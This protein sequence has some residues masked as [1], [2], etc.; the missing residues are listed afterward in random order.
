MR[1]RV[2][3]VDDEPGMLE[4]AK[5]FLESGSGY[6]V[7]TVSSSHEALERFA[8]D[9]HDAIVS[10]Y[11][12]AGMDG[13][14]L[15]KEV[16]AMHN[17]VPFI[18]LTGKGREDVAIEAL[19][20]GADFYLQKGADLK[21]QF[22]ELANMIRA[23]VEQRRAELKAHKTSEMLGAVVR[24]SPTPLVTVDTQGKV[25]M[26]NLAAQ[27][28]FGWTE[29]EAIGRIPPLV[30]P[31]L[32]GQF[33]GL[34]ARILSGERLDGVELKRIRKD[35]TMRDVLAYY[36][37]ILDRDGKPA[38][39]MA[40]LVDVTDH[41]RMEEELR[42][43]N[44][45][46][47]L[48]SKTNATIVMAKDRNNLL[49]QVCKVAVEHG[50]FSSAW[51]CLFGT[52]GELIPIASEGADLDKLQDI[53]RRMVKA[54]ALEAPT[55]KAAKEG[56]T[57]ISTDIYSDHSA[58][59]WRDMF[60]EIGVRSL[61]A[62]PI[63]QGG[64]VVG[65]LTIGSSE[66]YFFTKQ[67]RDLLDEIA[68]DVSFALDGIRSEKARRRAQSTLKR[69]SEFT[70]A[71]LDV[72]GAIIVVLDTEG[73][74]VRFN[75]EGETVTGWTADEVH[76]KCVWDVFTPESQR[77]EVKNVFARLLAE[78]APNEHVNPWVTKDGTERIVDWSNTVMK[79]S[80]GDVRYVI[81]TGIDVTERNKAQEELKKTTEEALTAKNRA[82]TYLDF[83]THDIMNIITPLTSY[84]ELILHGD[85]QP[86]R[87]ETYAKRMIEQTNRL[88]R[89]VTHVRKL[90]R[91]ETAAKVGL[92][93]ADLRSLIG[94]LETDIRDRY[95]GKDIT[96]AYSLPEG[97]ILVQGK[98][99][100]GDVLN[101]I[102]ENAVK[103]SRSREV[104]IDVTIRPI[105][106]EKGGR[107]WHID[108][109]DHGPGIP[110][111]Q[112][113]LLLAE[114]FT[115]ETSM[116]RGVATSFAFMSMIVEHLGGGVRIAD[117][118]EGDHTKGV[119]IVLKLPVAP[120]QMQ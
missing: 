4:L 82:Q 116:V 67:E 34:V 71:V 79:D 89:F 25:I 55:L 75:R 7:D 49:E 107:F 60:K 77:A 105:S 32:E 44:R 63:R 12:M 14:Q 24:S 20:N 88:A 17:D 80:A 95:R 96:V 36:V 26:W 84:S 108:I 103:H 2:L 31:E 109:A 100:V 18:L 22:A 91:S 104:M 40:S 101:E 61:G 46:Y 97:P 106:V 37:R 11:Q 52:D 87:T 110:D 21:S 98:G 53:R 83:M 70:R 35:G 65:S 56:A 73:R 115:E 86:G 102:L 3:C 29:E 114:S 1:I 112:K 74:I 64:K 94:L 42:R 5:H 119:K 10:D 57:V 6:E 54:G 33:R 120:E 85:G 47:G 68:S 30:P 15:L 69:E 90:A 58:E 117:R 113:K 38:G 9:G 51:V 19:N 27:R 45:L 41:K 28:V 92:E 13:I 118:V 66:P 76:G 39:A 111:E 23:T 99:Y 59:P 72:A 48:L 93:A 50:G 8:K 43:I 81:A 62:M 78:G 16:R